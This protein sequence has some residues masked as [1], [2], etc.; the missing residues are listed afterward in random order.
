[1]G[2]DISS[3]TIIQSS[4][5]TASFRILIIV[6]R[7]Q[8]VAQSLPDGLGNIVLSFDGV[9][10]LIAAALLRCSTATEACC[11]YRQDYNSAIGVPIKVGP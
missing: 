1:V 4:Y 2:W 5:S 6:Q 3:N 10:L 11:A 9:S 7:L 8:V